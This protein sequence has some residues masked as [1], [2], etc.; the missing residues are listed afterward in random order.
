MDMR[1]CVRTCLDCADICDMTMRVATRRTGSNERV[2]REA[3]RLCVTTCELC[4]EECERHDNDHCRRCAEMC[5][6]CARD[7]SAALE[8]LSAFA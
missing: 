8:S 3:L 7:C 1:Q 6:E 2:L 5:R 4:A